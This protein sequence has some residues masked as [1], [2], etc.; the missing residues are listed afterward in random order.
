MRSILLVAAAALA[1]CACNQ[2]APGETAASGTPSAPATMATTNATIEPV[3]TSIAPASPSPAPSPSKTAMSA[4]TPP[5]PAAAPYS[6]C[7]ADKAAKFV[8]RN[9]TPDVRAQVIEAVGHNRIRWIG[10]DDAVTMDYS[11]ERLNAELDAGGRI[12]IFRCG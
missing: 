5:P 4:T 1:L 9:A 12:R 7:G 6:E 2:T 3:P 11:E 10:P 8:G